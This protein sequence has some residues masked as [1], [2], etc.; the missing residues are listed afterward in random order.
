MT[1]RLLLPR[2]VLSLVLVLAL[3][4]AAVAQEAKMSIVN[5]DT[6]RT[7]LSKQVGKQ[8]TLKLDSGEELG[9]VVRTVGEHV[10]HIE[11]ISGKEFFDAIVD[12]DEVAAVILRVR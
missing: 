5:E 10:V 7:V 11:K 12:L 6:V 4:T 2:L 9:G 1:K 8:V 3:I